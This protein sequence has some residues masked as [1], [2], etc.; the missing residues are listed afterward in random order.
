MASTD[1]APCEPFFSGVEPVVSAEDVDNNGQRVYVETTL[2]RQ[3]AGWC[4]MSTLFQPTVFVLYQ[5]RALE[6]MHATTPPTR[7][8]CLPLSEGLG[9]VMVA[10]WATRIK[11]VR[12]LT[13]TVMNLMSCR[14]VRFSMG[15]MKTTEQG[16]APV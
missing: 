14:Q 1:L 6:R 13:V 15:M 3:R 11:Y 5:R 16:V 7:Y 9:E 8:R 4:L 2:E 10:H 12:A